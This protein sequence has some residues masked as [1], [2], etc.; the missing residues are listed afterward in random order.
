MF[1]PF[2]FLVPSIN[3]YPIPLFP[4]TLCIAIIKLYLLTS[5][6]HISGVLSE[7][8]SLTITI[9]QFHF[10]LSLNSIKE[11]ISEGRFPSSLYTG[12]TI[13]KSYFIERFHHNNV[14]KYLLLIFDNEG[15]NNR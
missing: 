1:F 4:F 12:I 9:S 13:E 6:S 15:F 11:S 14:Y 3:A 8:L 7:L 10:N 2:A 5:L